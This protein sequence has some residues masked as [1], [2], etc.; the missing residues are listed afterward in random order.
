LISQ[1]S[2]V[3][4][5]AA[6]PAVSAGDTAWVLMSSALVLLMTVGLAFFY[7]GLVRPK[8]SLNTMMMSVVALGVIGVQWIL[9]GYSLA[10]GPGTSWIGSLGWAMFRGVGLT[11]D[12]AYAATIPHQAHALFQGMFAIITPA[13]IS[14]AI[15]ERMRFRAYV[16]FLV[17]WSTL[18][19]DPLAHWVWGAGGWL[20]TKGALDFAGGTVVHIS[21]G[22]SALVAA[23]LLGPR[24][25]FRRAPLAPHSVPLVLLGAG[26]LWFGWFG[27]NAGS[28]LAA[29]GIATLAFVN[30]NAAAA[31]ALVAWALLD[32][33]RLGKATAVGA[34]TGA[35]AG[36]VAIT[37]AAGYVSTS[38]ALAIGAL[39]AGVAYA[40]MQIRSRT[41]LD[42]ALDVFSCHGM[43]GITGA[44]LTGVFASKAVNPAGADGLLAGNAAQLGVQAIAVL[45]AVAI[46]AVGTVA[47]YGVLRLTMTVRADIHE[48]ISGLDLTEHG[49]EAYFGGDVGAVAGPAL[50]LGHS[51]IVA[52]PPGGTPPAREWRAAS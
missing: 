47:I 17:L 11:P 7:G 3:A 39:G 22:V 1:L 37:P 52:K 29:N 46:A 19:Y 24:R 51:V 23:R 2:A 14:G 34:A 40:A 49:E 30:T 35:V 21:A 45:A 5:Q 31:A 32:T 20:A 28:A 8:N 26:L 50:A 6:A 25:D 18:V 27:F 12:P 48:E 4:A 44:L 15:V 16:V 36:L 42:D 41:R 38:A 9:V 43:A 33:A 10:F 13:L